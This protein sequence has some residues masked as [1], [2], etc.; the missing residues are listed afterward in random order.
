MELAISQTQ[1]DLSLL[2]VANRCPSGD[3]ATLLI[4][5]SWPSK[6]AE[7]SNSPEEEK[8]LNSLSI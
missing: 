3:H 7:H 2:Q 4:S 6:V 1:T 8:M 5:F